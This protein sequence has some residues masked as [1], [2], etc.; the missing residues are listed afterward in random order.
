MNKESE[1]QKTKLSPG[2]LFAEACAQHGSKTSLEF[3]YTITDTIMQTRRRTRWPVRN[4]FK[5]INIS[6]NPIKYYWYETRP[7]QSVFQT[8]RES[9][10]KPEAANRFQVS[11]IPEL[12]PTS[13]W[14]Q[15][16]PRLLEDLDSFASFIDL[17]L[18]VR[19]CTA[20]NQA[21]TIGNRGV[22]SN[23]HILRYK[24]KDKINPILSA[25]NQVEQMGTTADTLI[26]NPFDFWRFLSEGNLIKLLE[27]TGLT[28]ARTRMLKPGTAL[29]GDFAHGAFLLDSGHSRIRFAEPPPGTFA[30]GGLCLMAEIREHLIVNLPTNFFYVDFFS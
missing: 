19:L 4:L 23:R 6:K 12:L 29:I 30:T 3:D 24:P 27:E 28:I 17:R 18:I 13:A 9:D 20:E 14:V 7:D 15:V 16:D 21:L 22:L 5:I 8:I 1:D 26:I 25:C 2:R 11:P 10:I